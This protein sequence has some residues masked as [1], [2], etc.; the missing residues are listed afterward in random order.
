M[1]LNDSPYY[2]YIVLDLISLENLYDVISM[3]LPIKLLDRE[4]QTIACGPNLVPA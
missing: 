4:M 1:T 3:G 2:K